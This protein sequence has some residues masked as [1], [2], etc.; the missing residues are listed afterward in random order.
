MAKAHLFSSIFALL[1]FGAALN[2]QISK[3]GS[4]SSRVRFVITDDNNKMHLINNHCT[5][6]RRLTALKL[7]EKPAIVEF[8]TQCEKGPIDLIFLVDTNTRSIID[9]NEQQN[10]ITDTIRWALW[11][12]LP[13]CSLRMYKGMKKHQDA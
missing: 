11:S 4:F 3:K 5:T 2:A 12:L 6:I 13:D 1:L 8:V 9:F 7:L 10:R